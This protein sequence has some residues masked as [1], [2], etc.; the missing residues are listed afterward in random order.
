[1]ERTGGTANQTFYCLQTN[2]AGTANWQNGVTKECLKCDRCPK[3]HW[4]FDKATFEQKR[5]KACVNF[6][7]CKNTKYKYNGRV[8]DS[9]ECQ[10][11]YRR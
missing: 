1:M 10:T 4:M 2:G 9:G 11:C 6:P 8:I 5:N 3:K 7:E